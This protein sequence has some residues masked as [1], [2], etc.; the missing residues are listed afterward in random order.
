VTRSCWSR[1]R[2]GWPPSPWPIAVLALAW[3]QAEHRVLLAVIA[4]AAEAGFDMHACQLPRIL[5]TF[6]DPQG[7][8]RPTRTCPVPPPSATASVTS[9][10]RRTSMS[11]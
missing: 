7:P 10:G 5:V 3:F 1:A 8:R 2:P 4:R 6:L 11:I 9:A